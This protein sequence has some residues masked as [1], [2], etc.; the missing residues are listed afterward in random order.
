MSLHC[1]SSAQVLLA[2]GHNDFRV[3]RAGKCVALIPGAHAE[4]A[5]VS[6]LLQNKSLY[7]FI[8]GMAVTKVLNLTLSKQSCDGT[9]S[10]LLD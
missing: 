4:S 8:Y 9:A 3:L 1:S 10:L 2:E 7:L 6:K 5:G